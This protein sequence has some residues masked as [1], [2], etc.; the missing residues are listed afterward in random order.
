VT[1]AVVTIVVTL[2]ALA[3]VAR[4]ARRMVGVL[5]VGQPLVGRRDL[6]RQRW[7]GMLRETLGHT[8]LLRKKIVGAAHFSVFVGFGFLFFTLVT[9][10]GQV[11]SGHPGFALPMIG[12]WAVFEFLTELIAWATL[13]GIG[14]LTGF[15]LSG[16]P[17]RP[18]R[19]ARRGRRG[20]QRRHRCG[21][22]PRRARAPRGRGLHRARRPRRLRA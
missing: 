10:Y 11:I 20:A 18:T 1:V 16:R 12:H 7:L 14:I 3:L 2:L 15:R 17:S 21:R 22:S 5:G 8:R 4:A 19:S 9:A 13:V 6:P